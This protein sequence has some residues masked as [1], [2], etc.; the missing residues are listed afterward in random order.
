MLI[1][2][3]ISLGE[4]IYSGQQCGLTYWFFFQVI[5]EEINGIFSFIP[6]LTR[7]KKAPKTKPLC[8]ESWLIKFLSWLA[9]KS[10]T[11]FFQVWCKIGLDFSLILSLGPKEEITSI[12]D[13]FP[14]L[15]RGVWKEEWTPCCSEVAVSDR[16]TDE[17][18]RWEEVSIWNW[19]APWW[20]KRRSCLDSNAGMHRVEML[21]N[22]N[23]LLYRTSFGIWRMT[24]YRETC[25]QYLMVE[26]ISSEINYFNKHSL[27]IYYIPDTVLRW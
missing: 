15:P 6:Q 2:N 10:R 18:N 11:D 16:P 22:T 8:A 5:R 9:D 13:N 21:P 17:S 4:F 27:S 1:S 20:W 24:E 12:R 25:G 19:Y 26:I 23:S 14:W 7:K 3:S